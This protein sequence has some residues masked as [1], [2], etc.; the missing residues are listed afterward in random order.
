M[1]YVSCE[2]I[3]FI[4]RISLLTCTRSR[5]ETHSIVYTFHVGEEGKFICF[6]F[7]ALVTKLSWLNYVRFKTGASELYSD[8]PKRRPH[9]SSYL[10]SSTLLQIHPLSIVERVTHLHRMVKSLTKHGFDVR[11]NKNFRTP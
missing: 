2:Q 4:L 8:C 1:T 5:Q 3:S 11:L 6:R 10:Y 7:I 9:S